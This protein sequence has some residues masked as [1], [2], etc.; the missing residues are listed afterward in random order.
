MI[1]KTRL[2]SMFGAK[3]IVPI[4]GEV[5][6]N[7]QGEIDVDENV[8]HLLLQGEDWH[9]PALAKSDDGGSDEEDDTSD[10]EDETDEEDDDK[11]ENVAENAKNNA[12]ATPAA[13]E[14]EVELSEFEKQLDAMNL[15]ELVDLAKT[16]K[17]KGYNLFAKDASKMRVF[18][19][20]KL[21]QAE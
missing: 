18:L 7:A 12:P 16:S 15:E 5:E 13:S 21:E 6:I 19:K 17:L 20:K 10:L 11:G 4:A 1:L 14:K 2:A 9:A 8:A 3:I